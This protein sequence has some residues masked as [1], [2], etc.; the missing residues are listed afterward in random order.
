[1]QTTLTTRSKKL[2]MFHCATSY[3]LT[4]ITMTVLTVRTI[5]YYNKSSFVKYQQN[6]INFSIV[7]WYI[8]YRYKFSSMIPA[9]LNRAANRNYAKG[10]CF[11][12]NH[13]DFVAADAVSPTFSNPLCSL[14]H[15]PTSNTPRFAGL[16]SEPFAAFNWSACCFFASGSIFRQYFIFPFEPFVNPPLTYFLKYFFKKNTWQIAVLPIY[17]TQLKS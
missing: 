1:M 13:L 2:F 12:S 6:S 4:K 15:S 11:E 7:C 16:V 3:T 9:Y 17:Y 10:M 8:F 14:C 5:L